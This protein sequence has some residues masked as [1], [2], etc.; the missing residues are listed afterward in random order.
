MRMFYLNYPF[1]FIHLIH[2]SLI[3]T[4]IKEIVALQMGLLQNICNV[5]S[6]ARACSL[7]GAIAKS[8]HS[9]LK[10]NQCELIQM[11]INI[12]KLNPTILQL[13]VA[14]ECQL[15]ATTVLQLTRK[16]FQ[17][18]HLFASKLSIF[19]FTNI[20]NIRRF[21]YP[22]NKRMGFGGFLCVCLDFF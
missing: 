8:L 21:L 22:R 11:S 20:Q 2:L 9:N 18:G 16:N 4:V 12:F 14:Q 1:H 3:A 7:N 15:Q 17:C 5:S 10:Q 13:Q 19:E 6:S